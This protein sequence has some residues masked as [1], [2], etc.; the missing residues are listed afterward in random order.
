MQDI[1]QYHFFEKLKSLPFVDEIWLYGSRA[2]GDN[3]DRSDFDLALVCPEANNHD[4]LRVLDITDEADTLYK[5][6]IVRFD[7]LSATEP[8][9]EA[10]L[11]D[12]KI[13]FIR[14]LST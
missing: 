7:E 14:D 6:D 3:H 12:K 11:R 13:L 4:W 2:R 8:L 5:I 10:I 1:T 9:R